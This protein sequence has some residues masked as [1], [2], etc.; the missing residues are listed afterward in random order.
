MYRNGEIVRVRQIHEIAEV[1]K[2]DARVVEHLLF[3]AGAEPGKLYTHLQSPRTVELK[4]KPVNVVITDPL[5][6]LRWS[7]E[8]QTFPPENWF[9]PTG[10]LNQAHILGGHEPLVAAM[11]AMRQ[12]ARRAGTHA[13]TMAEGEDPRL[14]F[15]LSTINEALHGRAQDIPFV[16]GQNVRLKE[17][18]VLAGFGMAEFDIAIP[19]GLLPKPPEWDQSLR[20]IYSFRRM[21]SP[22]WRVATAP[23]TVQVVDRIVDFPP[24]LAFYACA[25]DA[26]DDESPPEPDKAA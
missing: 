23:F 10:S 9:E 14:D 4:D 22:I 26:A 3:E 19:A 17:P 13:T 6:I 24:A 21:L 8:Q 18:D 1:S 16:M 11:N 25:I 15:L 2:L 12:K 20:V 7:E 5:M